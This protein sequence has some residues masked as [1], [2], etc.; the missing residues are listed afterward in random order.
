MFDKDEFNQWNHNNYKAFK[1]EVI[2]KSRLN[3]GITFVSW[4]LNCENKDNSR[5]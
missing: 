3:I 2:S 5:F 4:L 1:I